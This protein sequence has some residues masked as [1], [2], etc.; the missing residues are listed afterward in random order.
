MSCN[1]FENQRVLYLY[2]ELDE[3]ESKIF[4]AH[5]VACAECREAVAEFSKTRNVYRALES[6]LPSMRMLLSL[7]LKSRMFSYS[8]AFK[9]I[10]SRWFEPKKLWIPALV[11]SIA[12]ILI[13][14]SF[15]GILNDKPNPALH[16]DEVVQ[17]TIL[18]DDSII[19]L[20]QQIDEIFAD[21]LTPQK[22]ENNSSVI[23]FLLDDD[24][25]LNKIQQDIIILSWDINQSYF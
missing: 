21:R 23:N 25:G 6:E 7:K 20:G 19:S 22:A 3:E 4:E 8:T 1:D 15:W 9:K 14:L 16:P 13:C 18:S 12:V 17:W 10:F 2:K 11:S 24:L 5:L